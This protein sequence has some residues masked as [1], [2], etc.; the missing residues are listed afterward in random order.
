MANF[1]SI[2]LT[3]DHL[4]SVPIFLG[5]PFRYDYLEFVDEHGQKTKYDGK[6]GMERWATRDEFKGSVLHFSFYSDSSNNEWGYKFTVSW[7]GVVRGTYASV[8]VVSNYMGVL[9]GV[10]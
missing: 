10:V 4:H 1:L 8:G 2:F 7:V 9:E 6:V 3:H 5:F